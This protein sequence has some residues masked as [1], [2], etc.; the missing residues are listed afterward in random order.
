MKY[1]G[2]A[3]ITVFSNCFTSGDHHSMRMRY[4]YTPNLIEA[5]GLS[6]IEFEVLHFPHRTLRYLCQRFL[7]SDHVSPK[8]L[9]ARTCEQTACC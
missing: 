2:T 6:L 5:S 9:P 4:L 3:E 8:R 1:A 7:C